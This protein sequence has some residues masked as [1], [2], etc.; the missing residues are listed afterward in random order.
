MVA[1]VIEHAKKL[2]T[3]NPKLETVTVDGA[4]INLSDSWVIVRASGT[5]HFV[6][7]FAEAKTGEE[8]KRL[9][10]EYKRIALG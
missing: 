3:Q 5:E 1:R 6:R 8:A 10:E 2:K 7:I 9:V 4:R